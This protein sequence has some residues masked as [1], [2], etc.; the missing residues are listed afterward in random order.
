MI[1]LDV[2]DD[3]GPAW[4]SAAEHG[5]LGDVFRVYE[6]NSDAVV[7]HALLTAIT[8]PEFAPLLKGLT[9]AM[10]PTANAVGRERIRRAAASD[11]GMYETI[12]RAEAAGYAK[13]GITFTGWCDL[14]TAVGEH[15]TPLLIRAY[16]GEPER[17][18]AALL[19]LQRFLGRTLAT[20]GQGYSQTRDAR[21]RQSEAA[22]AA[23][24]ESTLDA[25][26]SMDES[27]K[28]IEL[29]AA[30]EATF[31]Y[32][33]A[34]ALGRLLADLLI[35]PGPERDAHFAGLRRH[36]A[37]GRSRIIGKRHEMTALR[38]DG[39]LIPV[40]LTVIRIDVS[41][42]PT[43]TAFLRDMSERRRAEEAL[44]RVEA[45]LRQTQKMEAIGKLAG[46]VAHDFN[47][48]LSVILSYAEILGDSLHAGDP[49]L[50][51]VREIEAAGKRAAELTKQLLAFSRQQVLEPQLLNLNDVVAQ[52][53]RMLK[54]LIG[55]DIELQVL[56]RAEPAN[57]RVDR[58]QLEQVIVNLV[59]N[60]RDAMPAG[61]TLTIETANVTLD[62]A[63]AAEHPGASP[64]PHV[65]LAIRD[66]GA[67]MDAATITRIFEPF[68]TTKEVGQGTGLGLSTVL[69]IV[70]QSGGIVWAESEVGCG[71]AMAV[72]L[73]CASEAPIGLSVPPPPS[74]GALRG[75]ETI[76]LVEDDARVRQ[77]TRT[78]LERYGYHVLEAEGADEATLLCEQHGAAIHL[79]LTD[80]VMPR[81]SGP[82]LAER[83][84]HA[85]PDMAVLFMSGHA[86]EAMAHHG[87]LD[88]GGAFLQKPITPEALARK[89]REVLGPRSADDLDRDRA[90]RSRR[91]V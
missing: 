75:S 5:A 62:E 73:P 33:R 20:L 26:V 71:T 19:V 15:F 2:D 47:N 6:A 59:M 11:W 65:L 57:V 29:N 27:G 69:G 60:A 51:D 43:F 18:S 48:L 84:G 30:A 52:L 34:E 25:I 40:E 31:G 79:L 13:V 8:H 4:F 17:L 1:T 38:R 55:E 49:M 70:Q 14:V 28:I 50:A 61:G 36:L 23:L 68:F 63:A 76:L 88:T 87:I 72:C 21:M 22:R 53:T 66:T 35:P 39:T 82:L 16:G 41:G 9:Q 3:A 10:I 78:I 12:L 46:G 74:S 54:R 64:G 86:G 80:V 58:S 81:T 83:L 89:V 77:V 91:R 85:R 37:T 45:Q 32:P 44:R 42:R 67:G 90:R 56:A 7:A 24:V